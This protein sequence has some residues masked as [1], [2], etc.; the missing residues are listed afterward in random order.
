MVLAL[1]Y[2]RWDGLTGRE[3][4]IQQW[5]VVVSAISE[6][7][8]V[9]ESI[10]DTLLQIASHRDLVS[11]IPVEVL[12]WLTKSLPLPPVCRGRDVGSCTHVI[13]AVRALE[14]IEILRS[15]FLLIWSEWNCFSLG[16]SDGTSSRR[17]FYSSDNMSSRPQLYTPIVI[18]PPRSYAS[19]WTPPPRPPYSPRTTPS[20]HQS[21]SSRTIPSPH[22][23]GKGT[24]TQWVHCEF[25]VSFEAIRPVI[26]QQV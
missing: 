13:Q 20:P 4:L 1:P 18:S 21:Y 5:A 6:T 26:T 25:V 19:N 15:Y 2:I 14:D 24:L 22:T 11:H 17:S 16:D 12:S 7:K 8:D 3:N 23:G 10:V 9:A